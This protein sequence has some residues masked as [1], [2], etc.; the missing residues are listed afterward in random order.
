VTVLKENDFNRHPKSHRYPGSNIYDTLPVASTSDESRY[1][2][3][4]IDTLRKPGAS[5]AALKELVS[6]CLNYLL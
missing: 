3:D 2:N 4:R 5:V 6:C 1:M